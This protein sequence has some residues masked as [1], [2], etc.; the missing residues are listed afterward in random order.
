MRAIIDTNIVVSAYLGGRL[1]IIL[2]SFK[3]DKYT[4]IV[5]K[6]IADEYFLVLKRPRFRIDSEALDDFASLLVSKAE[7]VTP[8]TPVTAI[9]SDPSDN[10]FLE[11]ALAGKADCVVSGDA[12]LLDLKTFGAIPILTAREFIELLQNL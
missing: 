3:E 6:A 11:A 7:F 12:H 8:F 4:L 10:I 5:S 2:R 1:E 9:K